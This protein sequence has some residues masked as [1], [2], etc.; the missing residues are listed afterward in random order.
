[1]AQI[2]MLEGHGDVALQ[3]YQPVVAWYEATLPPGHPRF[4]HTWYFYG[5]L[6]RMNQQVTKAINYHQKAFELAVQQA[7]KKRE[8]GINIELG[9]DYA[10]AQ[11]WER[12]SKHLD[13]CLRH[14]RQ[15]RLTDAEKLWCRV[16]E[17]R[18]AEGR[19]EKP[20]ARQIAQNVVDKRMTM[21]GSSLNESNRAKSEAQALLQRL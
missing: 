14:L 3:Y 5:I 21:K 19:A 2:Q 11:D 17:A 15:N 9:L 8:A 10:D 13:A 4:F 12:V 1:M 20:L 18:R 7:D 6:L 16:L